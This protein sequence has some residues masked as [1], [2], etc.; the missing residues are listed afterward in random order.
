MEI[1]QYINEVWNPV[2][3]YFGLYEASNYGRVRS[4]G[5]GKTHKT[6]RILCPGKKKNGYLQVC[7]YKD[8]KRKYLKVHRLVWEAFNGPIPNG[9]QINH[10]NEDKTD[11]RLENL[12]LMTCKENLN[13][14]TRNK[15]AGKAIAKA[16]SKMVEQYTLEGEHIMTWFSARG[17]ERELGHLGFDHSHISKCCNGNLKM[18][19]GFIWKYA[20]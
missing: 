1:L 6:E 9:M 3:G 10:I 17:V 13:W 15:R 14:G 19:K 7:L 2:R 20:E 8:G 5:N 12:N 18:H 16:K 4:L 11:N